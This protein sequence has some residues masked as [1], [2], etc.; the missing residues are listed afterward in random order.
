MFGCSA[1][2]GLSAVEY[3]RAFFTVECLGGVLGDFGCLPRGAC[4]DRQAQQK[5]IRIRSYIKNS[6]LQIRSYNRAFRPIVDLNHLTH[7]FVDVVTYTC[8]CTGMSSCVG[9]CPFLPDKIRV[10]PRRASV[11]HPS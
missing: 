9:L 4:R 3:S 2:K 6:N 1:L 10:W 11:D 7:L 8:A 5:C